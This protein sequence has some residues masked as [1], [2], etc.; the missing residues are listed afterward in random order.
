MRRGQHSNV[1]ILRSRWCCRFEVRFR[2]RLLEERRLKG[3]VIFKKHTHPPTMGRRPCE[4]R[5]RRDA[6]LAMAVMGA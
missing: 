6:T 5:F 2:S 3:D 4:S 1:T